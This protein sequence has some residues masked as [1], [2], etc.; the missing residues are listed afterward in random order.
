MNQVTKSSS[1]KTGIRPTEVDFDLSNSLAFRMVK[2]VNVLT[3]EFQREFEADLD[4]GLPEWRVIAALHRKP[5]LAAAD[6]ARLTGQ[7]PMI[8]SRA[9]KR[10]LS[11]GRIERRAMRGDGRRF[12]LFLTAAGAEV[13][14]HIS[15]LA[16]RW[17]KALVDEMLPQDIISI[18]NLIDGA[19]E[20]FDS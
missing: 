12:Q 16:I 2:L 13:F 5:G 9:V 10:L 6:I 1:D 3:R 11:M 19:I 18:S 4:L 17:E 20:R 8:I 15:P 7:N 14:K